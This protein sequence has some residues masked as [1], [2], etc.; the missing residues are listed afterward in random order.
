M[1]AFY[2]TYEMKI[3]HLVNQALTSQIYQHMAETPLSPAP[4][5]SN[6]LGAK[7]WL[8]REDLQPIFSFKI[9]GALHKM[10]SL[11][12]ARCAKG[13]VAASAGNH[14]QGVAY[15]ARLMGAP[16]VIYMPTRTPT[17]KLNA[18]KRLGARTVLE[19][20]N[21]QETLKKAGAYAKKTRFSFFHPFDDD[22]V[23]C[24]QATLGAELLREMPPTT[25]AVFVACGG[26][27]LLAGVSAMVKHLRPKVKVFGVE[28]EDAACMALSMAK[29]RPTRLDYVGTFAETVAIAKPGARPFRICKNSIDGVKVIDIG[30]I[31]NAIKEIYEETRVIAEPAGALGVAGARAYV[32]SGEHKGGDLVAVVCGANMNFDALRYVIERSASGEAG[33]MLLAA[34]IPDRPGS[35][36]RMC[37]LLGKRHVR[38]FNYR[39]S[40]TSKMAHIF[41]GLSIKE[42]GEREKIIE[43]LGKHGIEA[44]DLT[45][46]ET[47]EL[48]VRHMVGGRATI[49]DHE[50]I[51]RLEFP[52]RTGALVNFL[53]KIKNSWNISLFHYRFHGADVGRVLVG[54]QLQADQRKRLEKA[55]KEIGYPYWPV[56]NNTAYKMFLAD[57]AEQGRASS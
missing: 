17:I 5:L 2:R 1:S 21:L 52:E 33:E 38:E 28:P 40:H 32:Q 35:F 44:F 4:M 57:P 19:G 7:L 12:H 6:L 46:D 39:F 15:A 37:K 9:R 8:K 24:G 30:S 13:V 31:C 45:G 41:A 3:E 54:F 56:E 23:I 43:T 48:H 10:L 51:Y 49:G 26:G 53:T 22:D 25:E 36:L 16:A 42:E 14:A 11:G 47:A 27:G 55:L 18:V 20:E 50:L 29:G 34:K